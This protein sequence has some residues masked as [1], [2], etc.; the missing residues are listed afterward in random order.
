VGLSWK[1]C[2]QS[3]SA[4]GN[5]PLSD[6]ATEA[7]PYE[8]KSHTTAIGRN[9][10]KNCICDS[11]TTLA[12][13][14]LPDIMRT[15]VVQAPI[16]NA[17]SMESPGARFALTC[18]VRSGLRTKSF[19]RGAEKKNLWDRCVRHE[20][21]KC[22][23]FNMM[24]RHLASSPPPTCRHLWRWKLKKQPA[25]LTGE[26]QGSASQPT[27]VCSTSSRAKTQRRDANALEVRAQK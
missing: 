10:K 27:F 11:V 22:S 18:F 3:V 7:V 14:F 9:L 13:F 6:V 1:W 16:S 24:V 23:V 8:M 17:P 19:S 20:N 2:Q 21:Q 15:D 25:G 26:L 4:V 12:C 5:C